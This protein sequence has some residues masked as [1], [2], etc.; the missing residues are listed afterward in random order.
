V[1]GE[2]DAR[3]TVTVF[4]TDGTFIPAGLENKLI[5]SGSVVTLELN[6]NMPASKFGVRVSSDEPIVASVFS[7]TIAEGKSDFIWSTA[8]PEL[9]KF[10]LSTSGLAP[11]LIF[12]GEK[13]KV[14][15]ELFFSNGKRKNL[16]VVGEDI[17]TIKIPDGVRSITI[18]KA[19]KGNYGAGLIA[20][21]SGYGYFP[22]SPGSVLTKSSVPM[23]N[24]R[25]L[26]P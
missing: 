5:K 2:I 4:S 10:T 13:V 6:P 21:K 25:V 12:I 1:P 17:A 23:S 20:T 19:G 24:I 3:L 22:L 9:S 7:Q 18:L 14:E 8:S 11:Q 26:T 16:E 15:L